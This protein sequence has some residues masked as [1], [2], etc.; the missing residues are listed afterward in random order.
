MKYKLADGK[1][2]DLEKIDEIS[3]IKDLGAD[4]TT[5]MKS[6]L[7]F[8]IRLKNGQKLRISKSYHFNEWFEVMKELKAIRKDVLDKWEQTKKEKS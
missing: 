5:I 7:S 2:F 3:D 1:E 4:S 6:T 8:S